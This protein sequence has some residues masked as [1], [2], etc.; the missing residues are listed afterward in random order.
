MLWYGIAAIAVT[1]ILARLGIAA[2]SGR[3]PRFDDFVPNVFE[4]FE[5]RK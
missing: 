2:I 3:A 1:A 4:K 5:A